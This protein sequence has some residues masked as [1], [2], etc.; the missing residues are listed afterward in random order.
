MYVLMYARAFVHLRLCVP[1]SVSLSV[2][3]GRLVE[4][5]SRHKTKSKTIPISVEKYVVKSFLRSLP[6]GVRVEETRSF[7][8]GEAIGGSRFLF[9]FLFRPLGSGASE[10]EKGRILYEIL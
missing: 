1:V 5:E 4:V 8:P 10:G 2:L 9:F 7:L 3:M 6:P